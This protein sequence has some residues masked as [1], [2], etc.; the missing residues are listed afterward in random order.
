MTHSIN[1]ASQARERGALRRVRPRRSEAAIQAEVERLL[2]AHGFLVLPF[3]R[4]VARHRAH[5]I[6]LPGAPDLLAIAGRSPVVR[7]GVAIGI[8]VKA[9]EAGTKRTTALRQRA[10]GYEMARRGALYFRIDPRS[11][12]TACEQV[13]LALRLGPLGPAPKGDAA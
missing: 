10:F 7:E 8:E 1:S 6:G 13:K 9:P 4:E 2:R 5:R 11:A 3:N 12:L